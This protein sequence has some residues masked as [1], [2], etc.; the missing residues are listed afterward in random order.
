[1]KATLFL[2]TRLKEADFRLIYAPSQELLPE[3]VR[4]E[5]CSFA[6]E[7]INEDNPLYGMITEPRWSAIK[8]GGLVLFG[9]GVHNEMLSSSC[10]SVFQSKVR[11]FLGL[12]V[13]NPDDSCVNAV[14][15]LDL[16]KE[17]YKMYVEPKWNLGRDEANRI[18]GLVQEIDIPDIEHEYCKALQLISGKKFCQVFDCTVKPTD[19]FYSILQSADSTFV[20]NLSAE[21]HVANADLF[22]I[23]N[24]TIVGQGTGQIHYKE[25]VIHNK[26]EPKQKSDYSTN[27]I[28]KQ[29]MQLE[30][31][32]KAVSKALKQENIDPIKFLLEFAIGQG[33]CLIDKSS[34]EAQSFLQYLAKMFDYRLVKDSDIRDKSDFIRTKSSNYPHDRHPKEEEHVSYG[35]VNKSTG[36][37]V[38]E[39]QPADEIPDLD[40][41]RAKYRAECNSDEEKAR[42][43]LPDAAVTEDIDI[44]ERNGGRKSSFIDMEEYS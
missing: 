37:K 35:F 23:D 39:S 16:Y 20:M 44:P 4:T 5:F 34:L 15:N 6:R 8:R 28:S 41:I 43:S 18:H 7:V 13:Q 29:G 31:F 40:E 27:P 12:V 10:S 30:K 26:H 42:M 2:Y 9:I 24:C 14:S 36:I 19:I 21:K 33:Y 11:G 32:I 38:S 3:P 22:A 25:N 1:M 17:L